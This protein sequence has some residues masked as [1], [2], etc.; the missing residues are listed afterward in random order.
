[1]SESAEKDALLCGLCAELLAAGDDVRPLGGVPSGKAHR[2]CLLR[3]VVGG[4]GHHED[5]A[6]WCVERGDP[7]G[8]RTYRASALEVDT[9]YAAR[10]ITPD[11]GER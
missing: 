3:T 4:I 9:L 6:L 1:M 2:E 10:V 11:S 5:H 7:D 8:G